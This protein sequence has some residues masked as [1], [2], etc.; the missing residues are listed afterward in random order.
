MTA[1]LIAAREH[2]ASRLLLARF[3]ASF[4]TDPS[5]WLPRIEEIE[6]LSAHDQVESAAIQLAERM[7]EYA[8]AD[9]SATHAAV[10]AWAQG[11][12]HPGMALEPY[13]ELALLAHKALVVL[14][15]AASQALMRVYTTPGVN[16][17][18]RQNIAHALCEADDPALEP[19]LR[20]LAVEERAKR[21]A[22][23][24]LE[25]R[26]S[27]PPDRTE[28]QIAAATTPDYDVIFRG[29]RSH[30]LRRLKRTR[31]QVV[32]GPPWR[33][34]RTLCVTPYRAYARCFGQVWWTVVPRRQLEGLSGRG[35]AF[36]GSEI[37]VPY[38]MQGTHPA[39]FTGWKRGPVEWG[40]CLPDNLYLGREI[41]VRVQACYTTEP[42]TWIRRVE[43]IHELAAGEERDVDRLA[44]LLTLYAEAEC[45]RDQG[46]ETRLTPHNPASVQ[47]ICS[48]SWLGWST[49]PWSESV[50]RQFQLW[51]GCSVGQSASRCDYGSS[52]R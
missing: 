17:R 31:G 27:H 19:F 24:R 50:R 6:A 43:A 47:P 7:E 26:K 16:P 49:S 41:V 14:G 18:L 3:Q 5:V 42:R 29:F 13:G 40:A 51:K 52:T 25:Y 36:S 4:Q 30:Q 34:R 44:E 12:S 45:Q 33:S 11:K 2:L 15:T 32:S 1:R 39:F 21:L 28:Q 48:A 22:L 23:L 9:A 37:E 10:T 35:S 38:D 8:R 46:D 20:E